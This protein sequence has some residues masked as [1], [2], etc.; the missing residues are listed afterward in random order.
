MA[1]KRALVRAPEFPEGMQWLNTEKPLRLADL[2]GKVVLLDFW[3]YCCINCMHIL[4]DLAY[5]EDKYRHELVV[6]GVHAAKFANEREADNIRQAILRYEIEH[7]VVNDY[8]FQIWQHYTARAWPTLIVIKP[9]GYVLGYLSGE[10][11]RDILVKVIDELIAEASEANILDRTPLPFVLEKDRSFN[12]ALSFPGKVEADDASN[13]L[14]I[15]DS[16]HNRMVVADLS[17]Q[18]LDVAGSGDVGRADGDFATA[19]FNH[20]QGMALD[21]NI[22]YVA[23]TENHLLRKLDLSARTVTTIAGTGEQARAYNIPGTGT[24]VALNSPWDLCLLGTELFIAMAGPHQIWVMH[25]D[26]GYL[27]PY[28]GSA[29]EDIID[30]A[31]LQAAMA[32]PSGITSDGEQLFVADSETSAIRAV[33][34]GLDGRVQTILGEGLFE[35]GDQ[36]GTGK[37]HVRLQHPLGVT[38][39]DGILYVADTY[40]HKIKKVGPATATSVTYLGTG[41]PGL[42]DG[43]HPEFYEPGGVSIAAGHLYIADTNNHAIRVADL[44]TGEVRTLGLK[45][46]SIPAAVSGFSETSFG[47]EEVIEV[48]VQQIRAGEP[49][50]LRLDLMLPPGYHLNPQAPFTYRVEASGTG[51]T[52]AEADRQVSTMAPELPLAI[53]F[54]ALSGVHDAKLEID[55]TFYYCREGDAGVCAIQSVRWNVPLRTS[56]NAVTTEPVVSYTAVTPEVEN[57]L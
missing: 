32:Q 14:F 31:R 27:E 34:L 41:Q 47:P 51:L 50:Q 39:H 28:A 42:S 45:G 29:R 3:T 15:A 44:A 20:P 19:S 12:D 43:G 30:D 5:L 49:G 33:T 53:P 57:Q 40:N 2:R 6:I 24:E 7:P 8:Q 21:G 13:R 48:P 38:Y 36:D 1:E 25:L 23:D 9:D 17:G 10:G 22:L 54:R 26:T 18:V 56:D 52:V 16:N 55:L 4:P 11:N 46:L 35:Y 37:E